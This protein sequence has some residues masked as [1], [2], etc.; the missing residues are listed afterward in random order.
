MV[1]T[2]HIFIRNRAR[3][4]NLS[5]SEVCSAANISRQ[6]LYSLEK[7]PS[8][9]PTLQTV[10]AVANALQVHPMRLLYLMFDHLPLAGAV[11]NKRGKKDESVFIRDITY[12]DGELVLPD[13][14]FIK[15]WE[16]QN[17]GKVAWENRYMQ[18]MDEEIVVST[19]SGE[20]LKLAQSLRPAST[21]FAVPYTKPGETVRLSMQFTAP[22]IPGTVVSYWKSVFEDGSLCFPK[23]VGLWVKVQITSLATAA[24]ETREIIKKNSQF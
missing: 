3:T 19:R 12:S 16:V 11:V 22:H 21:R 5:L 1:E 13:Q 9:L 24:V 10:V 6:T 8:P 7:A 17:V 14:T 18:C 4:L 2:L 15:T 20:I 23:A